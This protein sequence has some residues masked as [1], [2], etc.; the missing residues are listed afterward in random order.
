[1]GVQHRQIQLRTK[2]CSHFWKEKQRE[3][4]IYLH[5]FAELQT[6][7]HDLEMA[8]QTKTHNL[9]MAPGTSFWN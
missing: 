5:I 9:E 4:T 7:T 3:S 8:L 2:R 6:K 1:M